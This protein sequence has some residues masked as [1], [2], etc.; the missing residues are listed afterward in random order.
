MR[1]ICYFVLT[2]LLAQSPA[3]SMIYSGVI[4]KSTDKSFR[5][6]ES[7]IGKTFELI[8][9]SPHIAKMAANL[10][11]NDFISFDGSRSSTTNTIR[12]NSINYVGLKDLIARWKG[13]DNYCY[14]FSSF[15]ELLIYPSV[16]SI[17]QEPGFL[18]RKYAYTVNPSEPDWMILLSD[19]QANYIADLVLKNGKSVEMSLYDSNTGDILKFIKL[20][21]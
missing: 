12:V 10:K 2:F 15:T 19:N 20:R 17:C 18:F 4:T 6:K 11:V 5:I 21:K 8:F 7:R 1:L 16:K 14:D 3:W 9:V 13:D